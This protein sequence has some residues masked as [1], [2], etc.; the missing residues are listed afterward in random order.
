MKR[1]FSIGMSRSALLVIAGTALIA[2]TYGLVR[3]AYGLFLPD[4]QRD[5]GLTASTAGA[6]SS[7]ASLAYCLGAIVAFF[8]APDHARSLLV[9]AGLT[10]GGG[11]ACMAAAPT[12]F[13]FAVG[14]IVG[15]VG[16]GLASPAMVTIVRRA[17]EERA[18]AGTQAIVNAGTGPGLVLAGVLA[19]AFLPDWRLAWAIVSAFTLL[20]AG[21]AVALDRDQH[22]GQDDQESARGASSPRVPPRPWFGKH[23]H[24]VLGALAMGAASAGVW[25]FGRAALVEAGATQSDSIGAWIALGLGGT[26]VIGTTRLTS[27]LTPGALWTLTC[28]AVSGATLTLALA[29]G[30]TAFSLAACIVFGWGYTAA[31]G[32]LIA[33]TTQI[34]S[35]WSSSGT[36]LLFVVL[37][38]GQ[39]VGAVAVGGLIDHSG[40]GVALTVAA[41][42]A[43]AAAGASLVSPR[44]RRRRPR[45]G[46]AQARPRGRRRR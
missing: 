24:V 15:S 18:V 36:S 28:L 9:A 16:A 4:V 39:A 35:P 1:P 13:V 34:E 17:V 6:I 10:A 32:A 20:V 12:P 19:F 33:W 31:T 27:T 41:V 25:N 44:R 26:A 29:P 8:R 23:A 11:A 21:S 3:L 5:L 30:A 42:A 45:R 22:P 37:V 46:S 7:G 38:L 14:A 40:Y 43:A 2:A